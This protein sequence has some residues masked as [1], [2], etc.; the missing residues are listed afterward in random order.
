MKKLIWGKSLAPVC[1]FAPPFL[2][3][4]SGEQVGSR[5][6]AGW[7]AVGR[8]MGGS[9]EAVGRMMRENWEGVRRSFGVSCGDCVMELGEGWEGV[10]RIFGVIPEE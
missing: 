10:L 6:G 7:E 9:W 4:I 2:L 8:K 5:L 3:A 1:L